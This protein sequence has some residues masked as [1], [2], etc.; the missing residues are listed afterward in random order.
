M[1]FWILFG[2]LALQ[3]IATVAKAAKDGDLFT[4]AAL[5]LFSF[6]VYCLW[7]LK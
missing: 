6:F 1:M 5:V 4:A 7:A 3:L 2:F